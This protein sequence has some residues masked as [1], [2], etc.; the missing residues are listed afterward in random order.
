[1]EGRPGDLNTYFVAY[2][3]FDQLTPEVYDHGSVIAYIETDDGVKNGMPF[4][5]HKGMPEG[6]DG[7]YLWTE[8][9]DFDFTVGEVGFYLT[10]S[11]FSTDIIPEFPQT[12]H[13][14]L[15]AP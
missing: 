3:R 8:T 13:I 9:Y 5:L 11:D 4:V 7:A 15:L 10:Y 1:M 2:K 12:F 6:N 14:V